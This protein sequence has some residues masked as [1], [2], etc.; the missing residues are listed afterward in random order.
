M[1]ALLEH[2]AAFL[3][4]VAALVTLLLVLSAVED[5]IK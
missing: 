1:K 3:T 5:L 4:F 2:T